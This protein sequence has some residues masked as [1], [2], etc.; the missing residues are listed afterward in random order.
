MV[1]ITIGRTVAQVCRDRVGPHD[2]CYP[3]RAPECAASHRLSKACGIVVQ[4]CAPAGTP[5]GRIRDD[6]DSTGGRC[7]T[8]VST[9]RIGVALGATDGDDSMSAVADHG[10]RILAA[11]D[12]GDYPQQFGG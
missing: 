1:R 11:A 8:R 3:Q 7:I 9:G 10:D 2:A 5:A 6:I 4:V 12:D